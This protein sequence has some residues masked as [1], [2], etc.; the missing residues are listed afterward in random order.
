M[1]RHQKCFFIKGGYFIFLWLAVSGCDRGGTG[2]HHL[3]GNATIS[4]SDGSMP[5]STSPELTYDFGVVMANGQDLRHDF[6]VVNAGKR[7]IHI[8]NETVA[9]PCCTSFGLHPNVIPQ[10]GTVSI[11]TILKA[12]QRTDYRR[13][14]F[15]LDTDDPRYPKRAFWLM[16]K[17][18][19]PCE[20]EQLSDD[21][22]RLLLGQPAQQKY[23]IKCRQFNSEGLGLPDHIETSP[24]L[25]ASF[26]DDPVTRR[27]G[28]G[29]TET[30]RELRINIP[31]ATELG[32]AQ[33]TIIFRWGNGH[34]EKQVIEWEVQ[35]HIRAS[36]TGTVL[37]T[38][39]APQLLKL[40]ITSID[41]PF[42]IMG[43]SCPL[44]PSE[45]RVSTDS[46]HSH[47]LEVPLI[48]ARL[49]Q[50]ATADLE[51]KTDHPLQPK[52]T[53]SILIIPSG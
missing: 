31:P 22:T 40:V 29:I 9:M 38:S 24:P 20:I 27:E 49:G 19:T 50:P 3:P 30:L 53:I 11:P 23:R 46:K 34:E 44:L 39:S 17:L 48:T 16:A 13:V 32:R 21:G 45:L 47:R 12:G 26:S 6:K 18:I 36:P 2:R 15:A 28:D 37:H 41:S 10:G 42:R 33:G 25:S 43:I 51:I 7:D 35:P 5:A 52:V 8:L 14:R 1:L 4:A